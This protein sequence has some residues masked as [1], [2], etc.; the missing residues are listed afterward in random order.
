MNYAKLIN[1]Q[2]QDAPN[3]IF[4]AD[5]QIG[6]PPGEVYEEQGYKPVTYTDPPEVEP[7][8]IAVSG[9]E[10]REN[11]IVQIWTMEQ[12]SGEIADSEALNIIL[13]GSE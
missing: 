8:F 2:L 5:R 3:P 11:E 12:D 7:G 13:G 6:N 4:I 1:N 10:E 9:W